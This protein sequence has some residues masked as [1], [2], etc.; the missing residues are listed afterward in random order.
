MLNLFK[1]ISTYLLL[2]IYESARL[3]VRKALD[4]SDLATSEYS[5][6]EKKKRR[7]KRKTA[8]MALALPILEESNDF[9]PGLPSI[10]QRNRTLIQDT[11]ASNERKIFSE[12]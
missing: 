11:S 7:R 3:K 12:L 2:D 8:S 10:S 9:V 4:T 1:Y 6:S 5:G